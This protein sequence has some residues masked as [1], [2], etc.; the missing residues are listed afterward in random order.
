MFQSA[1]VAA[2]DLGDDDRGGTD[3]AGAP[4][5]EGALSHHLDQ[6]VLFLTA[7]KHKLILVSNTNM[8]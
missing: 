3:R 5:A 1:R 4:F 6:A 2:G 8:L 7:E